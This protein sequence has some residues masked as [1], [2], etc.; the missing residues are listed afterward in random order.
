MSSIPTIVA[1]AS[2]PGTGAVALLRVSGPRACEIAGQVF[3]GT[4]HS[5]WEPRH[6]HFG[7]ILDREKQVIDEVLLTHFP[8][9]R[10]FTG[11]TVVEIACHG[12]TVVTRRIL[13]R[14]LEVGAEAAAPGEF[15]QRAFLNGKLDLTQAE[16]IMDLIMAKTELASRA[17]QE[18]LSGRFGREVAALRGELIGITAHLEAYIDFPDEDIS[19]DSAEAIGQRVERSL[20]N[21]AGMLATA[22]QGRI[23][24][25]GMATVICGAPNAGKSSLLNLLLGFDRAIVSAHAGTTR[26]TIEEFVNLRGI[27]LRLI[28]TAGLRDGAE[29]VEQAGIARSR[30]KI[31]Q[32]ELVILVA[33]GTQASEMVPEVEVPSGSRLV[34]LVNKADLAMH[35]DWKETADLCCSCRDE[36]DRERIAASLY[37]AII[38]GGAFDPADLVAINARHQRCL[39]RAV[40]ALNA[41]KRGLEAGES[42]EYV[43][44]DLREALSAV[45][46]V[47]GAVDPDEILGEIFSQFCIGK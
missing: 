38:A 33:D 23:M 30:Q 5:G 14:L 25:E 1:I 11:E 18:Q 2:P 8:A 34:R 35:A 27:P 10:S 3:S 22:T 19:P 43:A 17:A 20:E 45:G 36:N 6:Q 29:E 32:A 44:M 37:E 15:S 40:E 21:I 12:G 41:A 24:R 42:P 16:A 9:P 47:I 31:A 28:D 4:P 13:N 46:D 39:E 26:D 7:K